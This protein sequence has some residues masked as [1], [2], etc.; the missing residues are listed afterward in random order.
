[1]YSE[2]EDQFQYNIIKH[3]LSYLVGCIKSVHNNEIELEFLISK[4]VRVGDSVLDLYMGNLSIVQIIKEIKKF[5]PISSLYN[6]DEYSIWLGLSGSDYVSV[7]IS[8]GSTWVLRISDDIKRFIHIHPGKKCENTMRVKGKTLKTA[9]LY[10]AY[11]QIN[12]IFPID[13]EIINYVR[14]NFLA[15][16]PV[17]NV[18]NNS[19]IGKIIM[20][21]YDEL[22]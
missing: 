14:I 3:H 5:I 11:Q 13:L 1:M 15:E 19:G 20:T 21:I 10:C 8:D 16:S 6:K 17:N 12:K 2:I 18:T 7:D 22:I 9:V 4:L